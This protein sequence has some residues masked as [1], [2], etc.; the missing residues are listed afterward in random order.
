MENKISYLN[1]YLKFGGK[2]MP[3]IRQEIL[4]NE[5]LDYMKQQSDEE[6]DGG[7]DISAESSD[8]NDFKNNNQ[9]EHADILK[10]IDICISKGYI[11]DNSVGLDEIKIELIVLTN[12]GKE[13][14][15]QADKW[16][17]GELFYKIIKIAKT[18]NIS[19]EI[20]IPIIVSII[21]GIFA[22]K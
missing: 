1:A 21:A 2:I 12:D 6:D 4:I 16:I 7:F 3:F 9:I 5:L 20:I 13:R 19:K 17:F 22:R 14:A 8:F 15:K 10:I 11:Q 18:I